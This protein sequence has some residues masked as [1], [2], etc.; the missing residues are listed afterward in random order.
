[1]M[2]IQ[3]LTWREI[4]DILS[5]CLIGGNMSDLKITVSGSAGSGKTTMAVLLQR[6]ITEYGLQASLDE[7]IHNERNVELLYSDT[8]TELLQVMSDRN[9]TIGTL[10]TRREPTGE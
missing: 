6:I 7:T 1:M 5:V 3:Q 4:M 8:L 10:L 2:K 9:I